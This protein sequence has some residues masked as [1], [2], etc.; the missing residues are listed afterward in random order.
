[1]GN[2][3]QKLP[4]NTAHEI[5]ETLATNEAVRIER[6]V[7]QGHT[8]PHGEWYDQEQSKWVI[9]LQGEAVLAF[10][11]QDSIRLRPGD[12]V[13]LPAHQRHRVDWT[14]PHRLTIWLAVHY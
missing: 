7:S 12:Y 6:I 8:T 2:L 10:E 3:F 11:N 4:D 13:N 14:D 9:L 1:M 5:F